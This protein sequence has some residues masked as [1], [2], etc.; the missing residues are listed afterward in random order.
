MQMPFIC[1]RK[2]T[3]V[4]ICVRDA[5][6]LIRVHSETGRWLTVVLRFKVAFIREILLLVR[7]TRGF[8]LHPGDSR[9]IRESW[10][11]CYSPSR[12][13]C[14]LYWSLPFPLALLVFVVVLASG[15]EECIVGLASSHMHISMR[16][17][18][19]TKP[20]PVKTSWYSSRNSAPFALI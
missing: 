20:R 5:T 19:S 4:C 13:L 7:E 2:S 10:H 18:P 12:L 16:N 6:P 8:V 14:K 15:W 9:I 3:H 17:S 1:N 11:V